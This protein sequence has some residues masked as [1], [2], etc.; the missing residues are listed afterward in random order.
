MVIRIKNKGDNRLFIFHHYFPKEDFY[1][2]TVSA[3]KDYN[4][5]WVDTPELIWVK[6]VET[7]AEADTIK[8]ALLKGKKKFKPEHEPTIKSSQTTFKGD[9]IPENIKI[10]AVVKDINTTVYLARIEDWY[11][12][13]YTSRDVSALPF[14]ANILWKS[15]VSSAT[16]AEDITKF[17]YNELSTEKILVE[18][19]TFKQAFKCDSGVVEDPMRVRELFKSQV[20]K[21]IEEPREILSVSFD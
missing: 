7:K 21:P 16:M 14:H 17:V 1:K 3:Y 15:V 12:V 20:A 2:I 5:K 19:Y 4:G 10:E 13:G 18:G 11:K 9:P 6:E 8:W